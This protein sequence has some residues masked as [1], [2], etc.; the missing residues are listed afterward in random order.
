[1]IG[2]DTN[3][4]IDILRK[5]EIG[6]YLQNLKSDDL[7]TTEIVVYEI[8][9]GLFAQEFDKEQYAQ[10]EAILD[11]FAYI[12]PVD[13]KA[14]VHAAQIA[15]RLAKTGKMIDHRDILIAGAF[16]ANGCRKILTKN[17]KDFQRIKEL[18]VL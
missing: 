9:Y 3:I 8:L 14:A 12:F 17:K 15:G 7:C 6:N 5:K 16:L 4:I 11:T 2:I 10:F 18:E 1:M 13:R